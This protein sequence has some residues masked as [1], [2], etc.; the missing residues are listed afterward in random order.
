MLTFALFERF[1][2]SAVDVLVRRKKRRNMVLEGGKWSRGG[3]GKQWYLRPNFMAIIGQ[4][5]W[6]NLL[7]LGT[8]KH[9]N[10]ILSFL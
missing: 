4:H 9:F 7:P 10:T 2:N 8:M 1:Y 5:C 6:Y 3:G